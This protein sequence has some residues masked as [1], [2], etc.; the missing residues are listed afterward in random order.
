MLFPSAAAGPSTLAKVGNAPPPVDSGA[1]SVP[2]RPTV[3]KRRVPVWTLPL[4]PLSKT[5]RK[6][7]K[8]AD[9][10]RAKFY[11]SATPN[12]SVSITE[13]E[14]RPRK[15][16]SAIAA[17]QV[18][19]D[20]IQNHPNGPGQINEEV[21]IFGQILPE[22]PQVEIEQ[23]EDRPSKR[24]SAITA[25]QVIREQAER[26]LQS[27]PFHNRDR[28]G[29]S[30]NSIDPVN[31]PHSGDT[32]TS[33][34]TRKD[35]GKKKDKGN[36][37]HKDKEARSDKKDKKKKKQDKGKQFERQNGRSSE[38]DP[39]DLEDMA[40]HQYIDNQSLITGSNAQNA[41]TI[42]SSS[43]VPDP[44]VSAVSVEEE[45]ERI[46]YGP[47]PPRSTHVNPSVP[48]T[49]SEGA[50]PQVEAG[51]STPRVYHVRYPVGGITYE[52]DGDGVF[53]DPDAII[54]LN[55]W[56]D[57]SLRDRG[58]LIKKIEAEGGEISSDHTEDDTS[59][60][61]LDPGSTYLFDAYCHPYWLRPR[62]LERYQRRKARRGRIREEEPWQKKVLLKA[63]WIDKCLEAR[64]FLGQ[65]DDWGGCRAGG[66]PPEVQV[67]TEEPGDEEDEADQD[68]VEG[69][70]D[71]AGAEPPNQD[72]V[73]EVEAIAQ[74]SEQMDV[75]GD[76][77]TH[78][79]LVDDDQPIEIESANDIEVET[80][81]NDHTPADHNESIGL[82]D[83]NTAQNVHA[84][85]TP[86]VVSA[87]ESRSASLQ[88]LDLPAHVSSDNH[89]DSDATEVAPWANQPQRGDAGP[90]N[91]H[92]DL[93]EDIV[94][95]EE[96]VEEPSDPTTM[97]SGMKFW[98]DTTYPDRITLIKRIKAAGGE[99]VTS[100][101]DSTH[102]LIH[103][104]KHNQWHSI[105]ESLT[106]QGI[107]FLDFA[108]LTKSLSQGRKL[109]EGE[110]AV[111]HG[112]P[113]EANLEKKPA[114]QS[115]VHSTHGTYEPFLS[116]EELNG[117]FR[118][119]ARM[120]KK[121]GTV[122]ALIAFLLS[123]Y[124]TYSE[125]HWGNLYGEWKHKKGRFA[126]LAVP[127]KKSSPEKEQ[128]PSAS[129]A[130][131]R[132]STPIKRKSNAKQPVLS[133]EEVARI[134]IAET[135]NRNGKN[136][137]EFGDYLHE[138]HPVY[139]ANT[140]GAYVS[141]WSK[142]TG[143]F[144]NF[145][146]SQLSPTVATKPPAPARPVVT[147]PPST[148]N[149]A[150]Q[151]ELSTA[152]L[153]RIFATDVKDANSKSQHSIG[154]ELAAKHGKYH[155]TT[156]SILYSEWCRR[157]GRFSSSASASANAPPKE[158]VVSVDRRGSSNSVTTKAS[159][160]SS[161][162][163]ASRLKADDSDEDPDVSLSVEEMARI[164]NER[165]EEFTKRK[166]TSIE[167][168]LVLKTE[169][170][171]YARATW[172]LQWTHWWRKEKAY[173]NLPL[174]LQSTTA[175]KAYANADLPFRGA[176]PSSSNGATPSRSQSSTSSSPTKRSQNH[177]GK[178]AR[179]TMEEEKEMAQY[180]SRYRGS[181][182][183]TSGEAWIG[184]AAMHPGRTASAYAQHYTSYA[185]RIDSY[186]PQSQDKDKDG[187]GD[188]VFGID[189]NELIE[190]P[191]GS[192]S[193]PV[194]IGDDDDEE[195]ETPILVV[196]D[197]D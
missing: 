43:P 134:L 156:W 150:T 182:P 8:A 19:R 22:D 21:P 93:E 37:K 127:I 11:G 51:P 48:D 41:I 64:K 126:Y 119:E 7:K 75:D 147:L 167:I 195:E 68:A 151:G 59:L 178:A 191:S 170:G 31:R 4:K 143:R 135:V 140:W 103:N 57:F 174:Y 47:R 92:H 35:K 177:N 40:M 87:P 179:Y 58:S 132:Q 111:L 52:D 173:A 16:R 10:K 26:R 109:A 136:N 144:A 163:S 44:P 110:F 45:V 20:H 24:S 70:D 123:K 172:R 73:N 196:D 183:K 84:A 3:K 63:W 100:Y 120:L 85:S 113:I 137:T 153:E 95:A 165:E 1:N 161:N 72:Q 122:K 89:I 158:A 160:E 50:Q 148:Q 29:E 91:S 12:R 190:P 180:I 46:E 184:Y 141:N 130:S 78:A 139:P 6:K 74:D 193:R 117:I 9:K 27:I 105:V 149:T 175:A 28:T 114:T 60:L 189:I 125:A 98:V 71:D 176:K 128:Q 13:P 54:P 192:Q 188:T 55:I 152:D 81:A 146:Y 116:S 138:K 101:S 53:V 186:A 112:N 108:W 83:P 18:I 171:I 164:F 14:E 187:D 133:N 162:N 17:E 65:A 23:R 115:K 61:I 88:P 49:I 33:Q 32:V 15:R 69:D 2:L 106:K 30:Q 159:V 36:S 181:Y 166:L 104:Y 124:A 168:G 94:M 194:E 197:D 76:D 102:V 142:R 34:D 38:L 185:F 118:R 67:S 80:P 157:S 107:W 96:K 62:D 99:L 121:G 129:V 169:V 86:S 90:S 145:Q 39:D 79:I 56:I 82:V 154:V 25:E 42:D 155:S 97:F 77:I 131:S 5:A 66:P